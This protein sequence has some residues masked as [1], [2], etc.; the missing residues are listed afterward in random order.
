[1]VE[2]GGEEVLITQETMHKLINGLRT[3]LVGKENDSLQSTIRQICFGINPRRETAPIS[4]LMI[5]LYIFPNVVSFTFYLNDKLV[6]AQCFK[7]LI[8]K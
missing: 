7:C 2:I 3:Y 4:Q 8:N 5:S 1:M 6:K